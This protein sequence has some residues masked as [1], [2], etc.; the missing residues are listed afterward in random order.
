MRNRQRRRLR[1]FGSLAVFDEPVPAAWTA[2]AEQAAI[3]EIARGETVVAELAVIE[4]TV[5]EEIAATEETAA[6]EDLA[7]A[8]RWPGD[9]VTS[10]VAPGSPRER[11]ASWGCPRPPSAKERSRRVGQRVS[12]TCMAVRR[13]V[14]TPQRGRLQGSLMQVLVSLALAG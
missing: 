2:I 5:T 11:E 7:A 4:G 13:A 14:E 9:V 3:G 1:Q 12:G 6:T 10:A 8:A